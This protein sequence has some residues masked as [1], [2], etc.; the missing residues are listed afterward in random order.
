MMITFIRSLPITEAVALSAA[1]IAL[2]GTI[3]T[4]VQSA[5]SSGKQRLIEI[6]TAQRTEWINMLRNSFS[7]YSELLKT[8]QKMRRDHE[9]SKPFG[10]LFDIGETEYKL[11]FLQSRIDLLLNPSEEINK[12]YIEKRNDITC[13]VLADKKGR[14]SFDEFDNIMV[15]VRFLEQ[16]ILKSEWKRLKIE[17]RRGKEIKSME[18]IYD[19]VLESLDTD[20][21]FEYLYRIKTRRGK[22]KKWYRMKFVNIFK[23]R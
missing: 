19:Q 9:R 7:E 12:K 1:L 13:Y 21:K 20:K 18:K 10:S 5:K 3:Y 6:V 22:N 2:L 23:N 4:A 16:V 8:L 11:A 15:Q 17:T 14:F